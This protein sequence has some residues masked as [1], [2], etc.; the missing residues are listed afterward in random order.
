MNLRLNCV[1]QMLLDMDSFERT[2]QDVKT[3]SVWLGEE[4]LQVMAVLY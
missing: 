3:L 1:H 2:L 4:F